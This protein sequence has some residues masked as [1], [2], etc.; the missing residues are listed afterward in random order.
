MWAMWDR[1]V[2]R[3]AGEPCAGLNH[4]C[5]ATEA[6]YVLHL[7]DDAVAACVADTCHTVVPKGIA[8]TT[9]MA[10]R[11]SMRIYP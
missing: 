6:C 11:P 9:M 2:V 7:S 4:T 8:E 10:A 1:I 5:F 3:C